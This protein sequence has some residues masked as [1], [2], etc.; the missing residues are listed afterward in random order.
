[1]SGLLYTVRVEVGNRNPIKHHALGSKLD[2]LFPCL[3][4]KGA[5]FRR[6]FVDLRHTFLIDLSELSLKISES[7][8]QEEHVDAFRC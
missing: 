5:H 7:Y 3:L 4:L 6:D 2:S 8:L 1:M